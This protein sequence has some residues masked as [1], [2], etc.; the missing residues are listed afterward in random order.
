MSEPIIRVGGETIVG[1]EFDYIIIGAGSAGCV[2]AHRLSADPTCRVL[3][4]EAGPVPSRKEVSIP[5]AFSKLFKTDHDWAYQSEPMAH[6]GGRSIF[7]PRGKMLGGSSSI[8]AMMHTR[9]NRAD[10]DEWAA[11]GN[12]G[13]SYE[14]VLPY[15]KRS[16][17]NSRGPSDYRGV[18]GPLE[19]CDPRD[20][21][22]ISVAFV[23]AAVE[24]G[25]PQNNE[26]NGA[27]QDGAALV[28]TNHKRGVRHSTNEGYLQPVLSRTN[29]AVV[30]DAQATRILFE[31][32]RAV[33]V[34]YVRGGREEVAQAGREVILSG[35][36]FNSPQLLLLSGVGPADELRSLGI[37][38]RHDLP[39]V[40]KNLLEH[41]AAPMFVR[42]R[43]P[44]T[45][46][47]A[48]SIGSVLRYLIFRRGLLTINGPEAV[49]F[50]RT[51]ADLPAPD[52][53]LMCVAVLYMNEALTPPPEHG[54]SVAAMLFKPKSRGSV[55]LKS[56]DPLTAPRID[57]N[58]FS[59][60]NG[61]DMRSVVSGLKI[62]RRILSAP[63]LAPYHD[64]EIGPG[65]DAQSDS[66]LASWVRSK[67]QTIYH[68]IG[69]CKMGHDAEAV[70]DAR[71]RVRGLE[72][73][74]VVDASIMPTHVRAH[75]HAAVV[76]I[77]EKAADM[78]L[79]QT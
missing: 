74:R 1:S 9:G 63:A 45:L 57:L 23:R 77:G 21:H 51:R 73:L 58:L 75:T 2:L 33:G 44:I 19:V 30:T 31:G 14:A 61:D 13:W 72:G 38:V 67:C 7:I 50:V 64:G 46:L 70:V 28:Q 5:A 78:I 43:K 60:E 3:V 16:E 55:T 65:P 18:D 20:P 56:T 48:E 79:G 54:F 17:N 53:E 37:D 42:C 49:A 6:L 66:D 68:P 11:L 22:P 39:G 47:A 36:A 25:I 52:I 26:F 10:F 12:P 32:R 34:G 40:G 62:A 71:L 4:L 27:T 69:T 8:N 35:G 15:F 59:D 41:A 76:M 29:L 24:C